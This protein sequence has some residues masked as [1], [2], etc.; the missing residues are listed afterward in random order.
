MSRVANPGGAQA[1]FETH[2]RETWTRGAP[3]FSVLLPCFACHPPFHDNMHTFAVDND[4]RLHGGH[5]DTACFRST[6]LIKCGICSSPTFAD[7]HSA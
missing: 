2:R 7:A 1:V 4:T 3:S 5:T 6:V